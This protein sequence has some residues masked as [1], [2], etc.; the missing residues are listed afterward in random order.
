[1]KNKWKIKILKDMPLFHVEVDGIP[2]AVNTLTMENRVGD[3]P[4][5]NLRIPIRPE[6]LEIETVGQLPGVPAANTM[7]P[8]CG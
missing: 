5:L 6:C 4:M 1:M 3:T 2:L 7:G 8:A